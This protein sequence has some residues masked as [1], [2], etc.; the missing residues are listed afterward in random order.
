MGLSER[1]DNIANDLSVSN[2][3]T[4]SS[5]TGYGIH[6][7]KTMIAH[8]LYSQSISGEEYST[9]VKTVPEEGAYIVA[10]ADLHT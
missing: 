5:K 2:P 8:N 1:I 3:I 10:A 9:K 4:I 6:K 7:L